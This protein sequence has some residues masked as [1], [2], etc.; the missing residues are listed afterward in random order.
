MSDSVIIILLKCSTV[1][2]GI[3]M[4]TYRLKE[5]Q[6]LTIKLDSDYPSDEDPVK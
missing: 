4:A 3:F 2:L 6:F 5:F 1:L